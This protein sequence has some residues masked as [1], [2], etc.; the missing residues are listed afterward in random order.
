VALLF[1]AALA[2]PSHAAERRGAVA[3]HYGP[4][5][6]QKQLDF[7]GRFEVL[8]THDPL[9]RAQVEALHERGTKLALY[10][11]T[12]A[13]YR[14][15]VQP[16]TWQS[17]LLKNRSQLLNRTSLRGHAGA[18]DADAFYYDPHDY[19]E[20]RS[21]AIAKRLQ[22]IG[23][24][25]VFFDTTTVESVHPDAL[26]E[27]QR[28]HD[29]PYDA[30]VARF[31]KALRGKGV[32]IV[33]NQGYRA[34]QYYLPYAH[35]DITESLLSRPWHDETNRWNSVDFLV[36]ELILRHEGVR[37]V[38]LAYGS[39]VE[40]IVATALLFG[41]DAFV[42]SPDV[43]TTVFSDLYFVDLGKPV[44]AIRQDGLT[45][46]REFERGCVTVS[47][48]GGKIERAIP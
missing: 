41:H 4:A 19:A 31:L 45:S 22:S 44:S 20:T 23:Y 36:P 42:A 47:P 18:E 2:G 13:F 38:H 12:V 26:A 33:T 34:A 11:W 29:E 16:G 40:R 24:D 6:T 17:R 14:T 15:L 21:N 8:V 37:F 1:A 30:A 43:K 28:R 39:D 3:F 10:E 46:T 27:Y 35:Y 9:P 48:A 5:L 25:G 32:L 7:F